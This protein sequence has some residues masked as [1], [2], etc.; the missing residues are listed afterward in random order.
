MKRTISKYLVAMMLGILTL[1]AHAEPPSKI[2]TSYDVIGFG[3][4]VAKVSE[5]YTRTGDNYQIDSVTKA[6][7]LLAHF[8]P[9]TIHIISQGK[10][11]AKGLQPLSYT[12]TREVDK[13][14]NAS[15]K[16]DWEKGVLTHID[17]KG[18]NDMPLPKGTQDRLSL[19]YHLP[20]LLK[21]ELSDFNFS[22]T[23][24]NNLESYKFFLAPEEQNVRVPLGK[25]KARFISNT[26]AGK[27]VKYE[28]WMSTEGNIPPYKI[29]VT[30]SND[31]K[32]TQ[33]LTELTI[34][35]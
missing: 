26:P 27:E 21:S 7:G 14:K 8:K 9:E 5:T 6:V 17:Y 19:L 4:T 3:M 25:F 28:I 18:A 11:T 12:L 32:L 29:I 31:G 20:M 22:I 2:Q 24:G 10:I 15:A 33:V 23:D 35:P 1:P 30:D 13:H 34:T 16:F